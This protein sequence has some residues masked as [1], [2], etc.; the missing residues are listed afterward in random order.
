MCRFRCRSREQ[1][2]TQREKGDN[3]RGGAPDIGVAPPICVAGWLCSR[4][5]ACLCVGVLVVDLHAVVPRRLPHSNAGARHRRSIS[6][7]SSSGGNSN[8]KHILPLVQKCGTIG[9]ASHSIAIA[10]EAPALRAARTYTYTYTHALVGATAVSTEHKLDKWCKVLDQKEKRESARARRR[11]HTHTHTAPGEESSV[12]VDI[13]IYNVS[14]Y[15][16]VQLCEE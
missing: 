4:V 1:H 5:Y 11:T 13:C 6:G 8:A 10:G 9:Y 3:T 2:R 12:N 16:H 14:V 15:A 7:G